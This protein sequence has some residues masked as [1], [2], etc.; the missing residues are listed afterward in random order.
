VASAP[1]ELGAQALREVDFDGVLRV[2]PTLERL[3]LEHVVSG[4]AGEPCPREPHTLLV[5]RRRDDDD[6]RWYRAPP[7]L[8]ELLALAEQPDRGQ[9]TLGALVAELFGRRSPAPE[10]LEQLLEVLAGALT[11]A[12]ERSVL[13]GVY[14][15]VP[16]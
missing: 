4:D 11:V 1:A 13:W 10:Q 9:A 5:Y 7:L 12:V 14:D 8:A 16:A 3:A 6:V 15:S 2:N